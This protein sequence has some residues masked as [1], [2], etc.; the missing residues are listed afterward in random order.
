M[1]TNGSQMG[2][3]TITVNGPR[4]ATDANNGTLKRPLRV[5]HVLSVSIPHINGYA[6]RSKYIVETQAESGHVEPCVV[7]SPFYPGLKGTAQ[8][9]EIEGIP[10]YRVASPQDKGLFSH[11]RLLPFVLLHWSKN[12]VNWAIPML[13]RQRKAGLRVTRHVTRF[14]QRV[15]KRC[16]RYMVR[17]ARCARRVVATTAKLVETA[18]EPF[19][20][21]RILPVV[22]MM[23]RVGMVATWLVSRPFVS[24]AQFVGRGAYKLIRS[25]GRFLKSLVRPNPESAEAE[26]VPLRTRL[27]RKLQDKEKS[28]LLAMF[29]RELVR[30][31]KQ[32]Q[33]DVIHVH[34]PY[35]CGVPAVKAGKRVDIPVVYEVRGIWEE[36]GVA[37][38]NFERDSDIYRMWRREETWAM[39]NADAVTCICDELRKDIVSRGVDPHRVFVASNA[40]DSTLF[41]PASHSAA[42]VREIPESV[43]EVKQQLSKVTMGY[44]GSIRPLEGVDGLVRGAAEV[45][46]RGHDVTLLVVGGGKGINELQELA[47][48]LGI[49]D[50]AV[51]TGQVSHDEVQFYYELIDIFVISRP[52]SRVAKLVTP[53]KPLEAMAMEKPLIVSDLPA[54]RELVNEGETGLIYRA[55][56]SGDLADQCGRLISD[57]ALR[58]RLAKTARNW[59]VNERSW[60]QT[61]IP[62]LHAYAHVVP[63]FSVPQPVEQDAPAKAA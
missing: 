60:S 35:F 37:Q 16:L 57:A 12:V 23:V 30:L 52:A 36:S 46:H 42:T 38:G 56:D 15:S 59:V 27:I 3:E 51:F 45:I 6:L 47:E 34:S 5:M 41:T 54:L 19:V 29:E 26:G 49:G 8:N 1:G 44:I 58:E 40:V 22:H 18:T 24:T 4:A 7:S 33:P 48:E 39:K 9:S 10:Y 62:Q 32:V 43:L 53:L 14:V 17:V 25:S 2:G 21:K 61:I 50:R 31:C 55:E 63:G 20:G 28:L 11:P 13:R